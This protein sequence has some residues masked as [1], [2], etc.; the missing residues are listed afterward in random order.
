[1][2]KHS[3]K[4]NKKSVEYYMN[5]DYRIMLSKSE[6]GYFAEIPDLP[7]CM[8]DAKNLEEL[9]EMIEDAKR[10]WIETALE[11][12][13][14]I[15]IPGEYSGKFSVRVGKSLHRDL[16]KCAKTEGVSLNQLVNQLLS[17]GIVKMDIVKIVQEEIRFAKTPTSKEIHILPILSQKGV[18]ELYETKTNSIAA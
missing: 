16:V 13:K 6:S 15:P 4:N 7:G 12:G 8:T 18:R 9:M 1:M 17:S 10:T 5:L 11:I 2:K 3:L 14:K